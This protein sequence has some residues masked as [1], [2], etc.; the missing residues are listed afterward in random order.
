MRFAS[1]TE[2]NYNQK[3][4]KKAILPKKCNILCDD[5]P[6]YVTYCKPCGRHGEIFCVDFRRTPLKIKKRWKSSSDKK[7]SLRFKLE[8]T[9]MYLRHIKENNSDI[10]NSLSIEYSQPANITQ[11]IIDY[12]NI[13]K[14]SGYKCAEDNLVIVNEKNY[15]K[16]DLTGLSKKEK[17]ILKNINFNIKNKSKRNILSRLPTGCGV[18]PDM[19][20]KYCYYAPPYGRRGDKFVIERH[21]KL[22]KR[23]W[24]T[25]TS[26]A[27]STKK[28]FKML[29]DKL[30][31]LEV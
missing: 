7:L 25:T 11:S 15:I 9:K 4:Y 5:I 19:I 26:K 10:F 2:Q 16:E 18:T 22:N 28:K 1:Q 12:N 30:K 24:I 27:I 23:Q 31:S 14:L 8:Q 17:E 13:L 3:K 21:P 20:P 6:K 29:L